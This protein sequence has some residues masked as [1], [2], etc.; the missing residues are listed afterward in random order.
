MSKLTD[1]LEEATHGTSQPLGFAIGARREKTPSVLLLASV[2]SGADA[3]AR[4]VVD[5]ALDGALVGGGGT[6]TALEKT[7]KTLGEVPWGAWVAEAQAKLPKGADFQVFSSD[8]TPLAALGGEDSVQIMQVSP[9]LDD[10]LL[11]TIEDLPVDA[12]L[13]S[14]ADAEALT[15][16]QLMRVARV[17]GVTSKWLFV[18][19]ASLP[20]KAEVERLHECGVAAVIVDA[21]GKSAADFEALRQAI[22]EMADEHPKR[23]QDRRTAT[24]PT[25]GVPGGAPGRP[26]PEPEP[27]GDDYDDD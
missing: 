16:Q 14:L 19:L 20:V 17:R 11:R 24:I 6:K 12:F 8:A 18:H 10:S 25:P 1:K 3:E 9:E 22:L 21:A 5:A 4:L 27:D 26:A 7:S 2:T 23:R 15:V 13:V